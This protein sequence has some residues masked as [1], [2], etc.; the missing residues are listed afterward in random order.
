[1]PRRELG[2]GPVPQRTV[3]PPVVIL[4]PIVF[5]QHLG[6]FQRRELLSVQQLI[7]ELAIE[8]LAVRI[9]PGA[10]WLNVQRAGPALF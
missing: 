4:L 1:M 10:A 6:F 2:R 5:H 7:F 9:L 8:T 3:R